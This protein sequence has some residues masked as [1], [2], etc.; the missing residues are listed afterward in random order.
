[1]AY[2]DSVITG[3]ITVNGGIKGH[4]TIEYGITPTTSN[5]PAITV[6]SDITT[7]GVGVNI[8]GNINCGDDSNKLTSACVSTGNI[9]SYVSGAGN[10]SLNIGTITSHGGYGAYITSITADDGGI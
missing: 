7:N 4:V 5:I 1:M 8:N 9:V 3:D 2:S 10:P 6:N